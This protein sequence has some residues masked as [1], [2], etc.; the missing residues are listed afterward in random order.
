MKYYR[1]L[2]AT[3]YR[4]QQRL[5]VGTAAWG[6]AEGTTRDDFA[7]D[8]GVSV[9]HVAKLQCLALEALVPKPPGP[10]PKLELRPTERPVP[11]PQS[12]SRPPR[13]AAPPRRSHGDD[14]VGALIC[15][16][17]VHKGHL[18]RATQTVFKAL[19]RTPPSRDALVDFLDRSAGR[20]AGRLLLR[21][22]EQLH[23]RLECL[24]GDDICFLRT[25]IKVLIE[26]GNGALPHVL[27]WPWHTAE[28]WALMLKLWTALCLLVSDL[29]TDHVGAA[30]FTG[31]WVDSRSRF[32]PS[33]GSVDHALT[34]SP[35]RRGVVAVGGGGVTAGWGRG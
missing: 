33:R 11:P 30:A 15:K 19:G 27:R 22:R 9:A 18:L 25:P 3:V 20:A 7:R 5:D 21:A 34:P 1:S 23:G 28:D 16:L 31:G 26:R 29:G 32:A 10:K 35:K 24:A 12:P 4:A 8:H 14:R 17:A 13:H 6:R 2:P